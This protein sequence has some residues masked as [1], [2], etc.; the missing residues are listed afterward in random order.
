MKRWAAT[1][2]VMEKD[3]QKRYVV[4]SHLVK[5]ADVSSIKKKKKKKEWP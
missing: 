3:I 4:L 2:I 5:I 1:Q